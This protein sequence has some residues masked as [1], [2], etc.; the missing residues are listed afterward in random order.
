L[1]I[2]TQDANSLTKMLDSVLQLTLLQDQRTGKDVASQLASWGNTK[3]VNFTK[4]LLLWSLN[5]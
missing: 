5:L 4:T 1:I 2:A 3:H